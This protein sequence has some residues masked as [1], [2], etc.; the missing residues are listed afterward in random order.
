MSLS[1]VINATNLFRFAVG[2]VALG[3]TWL[4]YRVIVTPLMSPHRQIP[5]PKRDSWWAGNIHRIVAEEPS[6]AHREWSSKYGGVVRY[7]LFF[8]KESLLVTDSVALNH[9]LNARAYDYP[10]PSQVR[11]ELA[12]ILGRGVLFAEGEDHKRQRKVMNPAFAP[13]HLK[14]MLPTFFEYSY[15]L[16]DK[17]MEMVQSTIQ[18]DRAHKNDGAAQ[19]YLSSKP[20]NENVIEV[21][22][23]LSRAT[24]DVIGDAGF[25]Y[26]FGAVSGERNE[27]AQAFQVMISP[28]GGVRRLSPG[29]LLVGMFFQTLMGLVPFNIAKFLPSERIRAVAKGFDVMDQESR[30][31]VAEKRRMIKDEG[32]DSV[33]TSRDLMSLLLK[34]NMGTTKS[35]LSDDELQG[36][37]TTMLLAGHETSSTALTWLLWTLAQRR[38]VQDKLRAEVRQ[39]RMAAQ[40]DGEEELSLDRLN[41]LEY[42]DAVVRE[43]LRVEPPVSM[44]LREAAADDVVPLSKPIKS[45]DGST[46]LS[47]FQVKKGARIMV[48]IVAVNKDPS[49]WGDDADEFKPER[50]LGDKEPQGAVGVYSRM[51]TFLAGA[52]ACIGYRMAVLEIKAILSVLIDSF[53]FAEREPGLQVERKSAIVTRPAIVG[54]ENLGLRMPLKV[55]IAKREVE[56]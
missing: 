28:N 30:K 43:I 38:D 55:S 36:Q 1:D 22:H 4:V 25:G 19:Q 10:K 31:I 53:E 5:G 15:K 32:I 24:L 52:R 45:A 39:A 51:L 16:R 3:V 8:G 13:S 21:S 17:W 47:N 6:V 41:G 27:L 37:M 48:S 40:A 44:T 2:A 34:S 49:L 12:R 9:I 54:E 23:W 35:T 50:W 11:G 18:D 26:H 7:H 20:D 42:L 29:I 56:D 46:E 14:E 33:K